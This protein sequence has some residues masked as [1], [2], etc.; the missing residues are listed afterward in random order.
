M[1]Q[2][3]DAHKNAVLAKLEYKKMRNKNLHFKFAFEEIK[4]LFIIRISS[5]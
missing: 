2:S 5:F 4:I 3:D 1:K